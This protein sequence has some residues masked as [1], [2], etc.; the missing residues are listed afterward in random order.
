MTLRFSLRSW[1]VGLLYLVGGLGVI[2]AISPDFRM[3]TKVENLTMT[4]TIAVRL[5]GPWTPFWTYDRLKLGPTPIT[6]DFVVPAHLA[7][8]KGPPRVTATHGFSLVALLAS[9][10]TFGLAWF[11]CWLAGY[12]NALPGLGGELHVDTRQLHVDTRQWNRQD[13]RDAEA[14]KGN[15][16][17]PQD[18]ALGAGL[19]TPPLP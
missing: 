1:L 8:F 10:L 18:A 9:T 4:E 7:P 3:E 5:G 15:R 2:A 17:D 13:A 16:E 11:C 12:L 14:E 6:R 19:Q